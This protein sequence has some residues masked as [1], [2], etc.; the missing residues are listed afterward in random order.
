M[1]G[2]ALKCVNGRF[3]MIGIEAAQEI[4]AAQTMEL[5]SDQPQCQYIRSG[6]T[7][8]RL[9]VKAP[10][11]SGTATDTAVDT[12]HGELTLTDLPARDDVQAGRWARALLLGC[13]RMCET[14]TMS[15]EFNPGLTAMARVNVEG[16]PETAGAWIV[17]EVWHDL[18]NLTSRVRMHRCIDTVESR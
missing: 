18:Y 12:G 11:G 16:A 10:H 2:A 6:Q 13:N 14:L 8:S 7:Y 5:S 17:Q 15:T 1:E 9:T 4:D 3:A